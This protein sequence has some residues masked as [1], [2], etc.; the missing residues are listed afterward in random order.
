M[1]RLGM[2]LAVAALAASTCTSTLPEGASV[3][4]LLFTRTTG[5]RHDSIEPAVAALRE[6]ALS[7]GGT[8]EAT[9]DPRVFN[10][11]DLARYDVVVFLLTTGDVLNESQQSALMEFVRGGGGFAGVHSAT[12]TEYEWPWYGQLVGAYFATHPA[13]PG[14][15]QGR[16]LVR[17]TGHPATTGL[18]TPWVRSDEWYEFRDVQ[19]G[20]TVLLDIDE[21]SYKTPAENPAPQPRPIAWFRAFDGGRAFYTALGHTAESWSEPHF[22]AH[23]WG[24][25]VAAAGES[26]SR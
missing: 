24:G 19:P 17:A 26:T 14:V 2:L 25:V 15:R 11:T 5:F 16:V 21:T 7:S 3:R 22:L 8:A 23:V 6:L 12:D 18:P 9:E 13:D 20:S 10:A 1:K 4:V